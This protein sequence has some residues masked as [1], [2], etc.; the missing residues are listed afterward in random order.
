MRRPTSA[1]GGVGSRRERVVG[2][3]A[4][5]LVS[6]LL[7]LAALPWLG[8]CGARPAASA[9][10]AVT[11]EGEVIDPQCYFTHGGRGLAH[12]SCALYCARGGQDL[13]FL[14]RVG[15]RVIPIVAGRHGE[16]PND[17]L[18][19]WA[20]HPVIVSGALFEKRGSRALRVDAIRFARSNATPPALDSAAVEGA[21][22]VPA[23]ESVEA[24][25]LLHR[26]DGSRV[27]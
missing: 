16:N 22:G 25:P 9:G 21:P 6:T 26:A 18:Y 2:A 12:R 10:Q 7:L 3:C 5:G 14:N 19:R 15:D 13:A 17:S 24:D 8:S 23:A 20:G 4:T 27:R 1:V 11:L